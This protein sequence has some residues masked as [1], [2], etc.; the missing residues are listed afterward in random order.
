MILDGSFGSLKILDG[1]LSQFFNRG[2]GY[3]VSQSGQLSQQTE[4]LSDERQG[5]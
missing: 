3:G 2:D 5:S 4:L 1:G